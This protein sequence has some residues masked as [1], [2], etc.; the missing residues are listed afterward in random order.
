MGP[1]VTSDQLRATWRQISPTAKVA[2]ERI[3]FDVAAGEFVAIV[4]PSGAGKTTLLKCLSG[5]L[6]PTAGVATFE[7]ARISEPPPKMAL[8]FQDYGRS[9]FPWMSAFTNIEYPLALMT[10]S[11]H[12]TISAAKGAPIQWLK[13]P[14]MIMSP[15]TISSYARGESS[16]SVRTSR[17]SCPNF[18][19]GS[20]RWSS[21]KS[22]SA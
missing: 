13:M 12:S 14:P 16:T 17:R 9:L 6:E 8:V 2:I 20:T 1:P 7:G 15:N 22:P 21:R 10:L 11:Y 5:L 18:G 4:G 3:D 19:T